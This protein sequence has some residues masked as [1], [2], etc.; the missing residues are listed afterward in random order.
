MPAYPFL[1]LDFDGPILVSLGPART[2]ILEAIGKY[3]SIA[4][5]AQAL[6]VTYRHTW[7][8][9][10]RL[11]RE[12]RAPLVVLQRGGTDAGAKLTDLGVAMIERYRAMERDARAAIAPHLLAFDDLLGYD[13]NKAYA[14][15]PWAEPQLESKD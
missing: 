6:G 8:V 11:N 2:A 15:R 12:F 5:A 13:R 4:G 14:P 9:V 10:K 3:G 7:A 1:R